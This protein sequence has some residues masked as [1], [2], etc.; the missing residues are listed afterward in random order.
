MV[1]PPPPFAV[2]GLLEGLCQGLL[3]TRSVKGKV[4]TIIPEEGTSMAAAAAKFRGLELG[5][6]SGWYLAL[7]SA[8][9]KASVRA[10]EAGGDPPSLG[11]AG[12]L[13]GPLALTAPHQIREGEGLGHPPC[14]RHSSPCTGQ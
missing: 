5:G 8:C 9:R 2:L 14:G 3:V 6:I 7:V 4:W 12:T 13:P 11:G 10:L 1:D